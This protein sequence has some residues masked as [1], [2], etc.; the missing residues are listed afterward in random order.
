M[1]IP[2]SICLSCPN[3]PTCDYPCRDRARNLGEF[4]KFEGKL[5]RKIAKGIARTTGVPW[6]SD[7]VR[8]A[9]NYVTKKV[10]DFLRE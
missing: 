5:K 3:E 9:S 8:T 1:K 7:L 4:N 10:V 6:K 2:V